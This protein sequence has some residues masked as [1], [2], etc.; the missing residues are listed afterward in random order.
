MYVAFTRCKQYLIIFGSEIDNNA[1]MY[2]WY[3]FANFAMKHNHQN[4][5][6]NLLEKMKLVLSNGKFKFT[7]N[8]I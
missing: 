2:S 4:Y 6:I 8:M 1:D 7:Q 3:D 5:T